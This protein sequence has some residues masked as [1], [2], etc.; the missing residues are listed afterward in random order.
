MSVWSKTPKINCGYQDTIV[1]YKRQ[2]IYLSP[3]K[4]NKSNDNHMHPPLFSSIDNKSRDRELL[5]QLNKKNRI[6]ILENTWAHRMVQSIKKQFY[7]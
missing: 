3:K 7:Y 5:Q 1:T 6:G 2:T 4:N